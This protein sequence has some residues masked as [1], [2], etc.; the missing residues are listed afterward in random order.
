ML[1]QMDLHICLD[2]YCNLEKQESIFLKTIETIY[3]R[4]NHKNPI[5]IEENMRSE[6]LLKVLEVSGFLVSTD[7][8][9]NKIAVLPQGRLLV[10]CAD[11]CVF[12]S[13]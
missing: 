13:V 11:E 5:V 6:R 3:H 10:E 4:F 7:V 12:C 8:G 9:N 2:C 1:K